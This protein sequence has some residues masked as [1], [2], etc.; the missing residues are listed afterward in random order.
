MRYQEILGFGAAFTDASCYLFGQLSAQ[1]RKALLSELF[2]AEGL[3][4]SVGRTCIGSSDYSRNVYSYDEVE[5][6]D[7][8]LQHFSIEHDRG[9]I[10]P[11][12]RMARE[13]NPELFLF[14]S[15]WSPPGWMKAGGSMLGGS[16]RQ[17]YLAPYAEYFV[18]F[19]RGYAAE[20]VKIN[21]VTVQNE[22]DTDQDGRMPA[23]LWA[24]EY[25]A[26]FI[27]KHLGPALERA[28]L[29]TKI[30]MLDHNYNLW[31]RAAD[32]LSDPEVY[33]YVDGVAWHGYVGT[34]SA[35]TRVHDLFPAKHAYWTEGGP[36]ISSA[37]YATDWT[38]WSQTF[39]GILR[40]W[41]RCIV[42]WNLAL[43]E[44]GK[45]NIGPFPCGG[46]VT[47]DSKT[48]KIIRSGQYWA[49]AHF[50]KSIQRGARIVASHGE[51]AGIDHVAAVNPNGSHVLVLTNHGQEQ[52]VPCSFGSSV[53]QVKVPKNSVATL[54]W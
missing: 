12:L 35:M 15:P 31:G 8:E 46:L 11:S 38:S 47:I 21:G 23:A 20:G 6:P 36:D 33:K 27:K 7:P 44:Q 24:Q 1:D 25:E 42:G 54:L 18:K 9:Y 34:S 19:L 26:E 2:G 50:S 13:L 22:V 29:D 41:A 43:D 5:Q 16:M 14:S 32:E 30:W 48:Q 51:L 28:G 53:L 37:D 45:P 49:F 17:K 52:M 39:T 4:L 40:N 3:R 10:L